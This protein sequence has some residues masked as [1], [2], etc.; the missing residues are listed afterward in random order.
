M[1]SKPAI[2]KKSKLPLILGVIAIL[3]GAIALLIGWMGYGGYIFGIPALLLATYSYNRDHKVLGVLGIVFS[4]IGIAESFAVMQVL[5]PTMKQTI[6][7]GFE[8]LKPEEIE[9]R[10]GEPVKLNG[11]VL[12]VDNVK[13]SDRVTEIGFLGFNTTY[14]SRPGYKFVLLYITIENKGN[15]PES[16]LEIYNESV[17]TDKGY[18][19]EASYFYQLTE[20]R[21]YKKHDANELEVKNYAC[22][23]VSMSIFDKLLPGEKASFCEFFEI[24]E[25]EKPLAFQFNVGIIKGKVV[26]V[27]LAES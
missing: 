9:V 7:K 20:K 2:R 23:R 1:K 15:K 13:I 10:L 17:V 22:E 24:R 11:I 26:K 18:F 5:I 8:Q 6:E 3:L 14:I 16:T 19:Y 4:V 12:T 25:D 27:N 21:G